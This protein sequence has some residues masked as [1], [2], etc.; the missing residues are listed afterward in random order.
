MNILCKEDD[1]YCLALRQK[2][3]AANSILRALDNGTEP[4]DFDVSEEQCRIRSRL[5]REYYRKCRS[6]EVKKEEVKSSGQ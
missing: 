4:Y 1:K 3:D 2:I 6:G 5:E